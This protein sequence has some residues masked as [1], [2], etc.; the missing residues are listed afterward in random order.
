MSDK[1]VTLASQE[2][3][4]AEWAKRAAQE[5]KEKEIL[6]GEGE[7]KRRQLLM[8]ADNQLEIKLKYWL[9]ANQYYA[10]ALGKHRLVPDIQMGGEGKAAGSTAA[11][12]VALGFVWRR[13]QTRYTRCSYPIAVLPLSY[14]RIGYNTLLCGNV[15]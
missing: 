13:K 11:D 6:L 12:L 2:F 7:S 5:T 3:E 4:V 15:S 1:A 10:D 14:A 9:S 8:A